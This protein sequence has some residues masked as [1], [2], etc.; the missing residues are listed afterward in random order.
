MS[1]SWLCSPT[2]DNYDDDYYDYDYRVLLLGHGCHR[3]LGHR[4]QRY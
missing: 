2:S 3:L 1:A 4:G